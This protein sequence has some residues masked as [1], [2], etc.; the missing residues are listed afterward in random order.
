MNRILIQKYHA[1]E[2]LYSKFA[3]VAG[4]LQSTS[5]E[6][7]HLFVYRD[8]KKM[9]VLLNILLWEVFFADYCH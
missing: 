4:W 2:P 6:S 8:I 7:G 1:R 5:A 3:V 9:F